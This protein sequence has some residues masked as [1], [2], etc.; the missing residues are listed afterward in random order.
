MPG[1]RLLLKDRQAGDEG[2]RARIR[3]ALAQHGID[4][5]RV[6][7]IDWT[8]DWQS[9]LALYDRLDIALDPVPLNSG[10]TAFDA[11]WMGVPLLGVEGDWMGGR[12]TA[13][14]LRAL[15]KPE[16]VVK[17]EGEYVAGV[18]ALARDVAARTRLRAGQRALM[19]KSPLCNCAELARVLGDAFESMF[20]QRAANRQAASSILA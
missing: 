6:E 14:I 13:A 20:D 11:L 2:V 4:G 5:A 12:M 8:P 9:H 1:S 16:W 7:F 17:N 3:S 18:T 19:A 10:T 15:G